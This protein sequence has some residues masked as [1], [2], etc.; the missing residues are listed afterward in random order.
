M[1]RRREGGRSDLLGILG[2]YPHYYFHLGGAYIMSYEWWAVL[3][4]VAAVVLLTWG[5]E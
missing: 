5:A 3:A 1:T 2:S 4:I